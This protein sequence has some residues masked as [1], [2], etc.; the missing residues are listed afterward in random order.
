MT[1]PAGGAGQTVVQ[2]LIQQLT[3]PLQEAAKTFS[4]KIAETLAKEVEQTTKAFKEAHPAVTQVTDSVV[5]WTA[6]VTQS[7]GSVA[8]MSGSARDMIR[9]TRELRQEITK[10]LDAIPALDS[11]RLRFMQAGEAIKKMNLE[12]V[13]ATASNLRS[14]AV[15]RLSAAGTAIMTAATRV[16]TVA[17]RALNVVLRLNPIGLVITAITLL[18][19]AVVLA[20][21]RSTTFRN[22]V[23]AAFTAVR[24]VAL[25][26]F[27][28][29]RNAVAVVWPFITRVIRIAVTLIRAYVTTYFTAVRSV[30]TTIFNAVR[31]VITTIWTGIRTVISGAVSAVVRTIQGI[32]QVFTIVRDAFTWARSAAG[33]AIGGVVGFVQ[34]LPRRVV[35]ALGNIGRTL[36]GSGRDLIQGFINGLRDMAGR[37]VSAIKDFILDKIPGPIKS[38]LGIGSPSRLM[39]GIGRNIGEGLVVGIDRSRDMVGQAMQRLVPTPRA[40]VIGPAVVGLAEGPLAAGAVRSRRVTGGTAPVT[41]NVYPQPGQSEYEIGR[42]AARELAWAAKH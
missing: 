5:G 27:N 40:A 38:F 36:Y 2:Q 41:V 14:A 33:D 17:Q 13:K 7:T 18:V 11:L 34:G 3:A 29:I 25:A 30:V 16:W 12:T 6:A 28:A 21:R 35:G 19:S 26:V 22:I 10:V 31:A 23:N 15:A 37:V 8:A 32:R 24:S 42:I 39:A 4:T 1:Q 9:N 20:Y